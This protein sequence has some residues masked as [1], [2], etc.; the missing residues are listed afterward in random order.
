MTDAVK[1]ENR[2]VEL[3]L[4]AEPAYVVRG[5]T[6]LGTEG[7]SPPSPLSHA[8]AGRVAQ[9]AAVAHP[10][11]GVRGMAGRSLQESRGDAEPPGDE[12]K[13]DLERALQTCHELSLQ[14]NGLVR[15]A[16]G[17][18]CF[19]R[20]TGDTTARPSPACGTCAGSR[21]GAPSS[22]SSWRGTGASSRPPQDARLAQSGEDVHDHPEAG[23]GCPGGRAGGRPGDRP[24]GARARRGRDGAPGGPARSPGRATGPPDGGHPRRGHAHRL[25][26]RGH[27]APG[28][29]ASQCHRG[30]RDVRRDLSHGGGAPGDL[31]GGPGNS[32]GRGCQASRPPGRRSL[33]ARHEPGWPAPCRRPS[34]GSSFR[35]GSS[36]PR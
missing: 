14:R 17:L 7:A 19:R 20:P 26:T 13:Q 22:A 5:V 1:K 8:C 27:G 33:G 16:Q 10:S 23:R 35:I 2:R 6:R 15:F 28:P 25:C 12:E 32:C 9:A 29:L 36:R 31:I 18:P 11:R 34:M 3:A 30:G 4:Y 21:S 24:G